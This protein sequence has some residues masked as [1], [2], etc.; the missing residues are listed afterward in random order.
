VG[1]LTLIERANEGSRNEV[2]RGSLDGR[3]VSVRQSRRSAESL[4]WELELLAELTQRGFNVPVPIAT[5][6]GSLS[7]DGTVV[8]PWVEGRPPMTAADWSAVAFELRRLHAECADLPQ[9]PGC[10]AVTE[11][12][13]QSSSVDADLSRLP[14]D[15]ATTVLGV[16]ASMRDAP[17][18][19]VHG[20]PDASNIRL[21][22][23]GRVWLLDWDESRIDV[24]WHDL[25]NLGVQVLSNSDRE[26]AVRLSNAWEAANAWLTES[27]YARRRFD[28]LRS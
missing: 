11:L 5:R 3:A 8:Q 25:S 24:T 28:A 9:R 18:S 23:L 12:D 10:R 15:V 20:D 26:R 7:S 27:A 19:V 13:R 22:P 14:D 17:Q 2:W 21:D 1:D 4:Q 16:F 6:T